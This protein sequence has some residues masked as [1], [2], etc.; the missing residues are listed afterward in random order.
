MGTAPE[1]AGSV[2]AAPR[3]LRGSVEVAGVLIDPEL[4]GLAVA[5]S[6]ALERYDRAAPPRLVG[7]RWLCVWGRPQRMQVDA[8]PGLPLVWLDAAREVL[9]ACVLSPDE[10]VRITDR[11]LVLAEGG[12][13]EVLSIDSLPML[14]PATLIDVDEVELVYLRAPGDA[15]DRAARTTSG[16]GGGGAARERDDGRGFAR[17]AGGRARRFG[18]PRH[19]RAEASDGAV[20]SNP[21]AAECVPTGTE[22][23]ACDP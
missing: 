21:P 12:A 17:L 6:R 2:R 11:T 5:R 3:L 10:L 4:V 16:R 22:T 20:R 13:L 9:S 8:A 14:D 18:P 7:R 23:S 15:P 1:R 19:D